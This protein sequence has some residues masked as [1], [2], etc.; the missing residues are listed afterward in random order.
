MAKKKGPGGKWLLPVVA[1]FAG[2]IGVLGTQMSISATDTAQF[3][4]NCHVM[5]E[6]VWTHQQ[7][8]HAKQACNECHIPHDNIVNKLSYKAMIGI[9]DIVVNT[10]MDVEDTIMADDKMKQVIKDNCI[11]CHY[12][13]IKEVDMDVKGL[14]TDCHRSVPHMNKLPIDRRKAADV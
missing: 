14:C 4:G 3:C 11:R 7:G 12:A 2:I 1:F 6:A 9:N 13:T 8:A 10:F 5:S